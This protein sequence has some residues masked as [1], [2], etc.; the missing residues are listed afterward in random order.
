MINGE[1]WLKDGR[2][3]DLEYVLVKNYKHSDF[4]KLPVKPSPNLPDMYA[5]YLYPSM[6]LFEGTI[7]SV[8]RGT[9]KPFRV[10]GFPGNKIGDDTFT[11][12]SKPG[13]R[14]PLYEGKECRGVDMT[15]QVLKLLKNKQIDLDLLRNF[16]K[17]SSDSTRFFNTFFTKLAGNKALEQQLKEGLGIAEIRQSWQKNLAKYKLMRKKY[18]LYKDV[19]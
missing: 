8:G 4:Y 19:E 10:F 2:Q 13:A 16:Y 1:H 14:K 11:P 18:L 9:D 7:V 12:Q 15:S 6:C 17:N 5:V 3:C